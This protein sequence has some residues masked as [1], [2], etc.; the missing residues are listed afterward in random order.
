MS[1]MK[2]ALKSHITTMFGE[3]HLS[4]YKVFSQDLLKKHK[5]GIKLILERMHC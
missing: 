1:C 4:F 3:Y 2:Q 5:L